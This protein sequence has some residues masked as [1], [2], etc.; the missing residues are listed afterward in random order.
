M[1]SVSGNSVKSL[2]V[3]PLLLDERD[4]FLE[5]NGDGVV[6]RGPEVVEGGLNLQEFKGGGHF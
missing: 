5:E 1:G 6:G 4:G 3:E 2:G